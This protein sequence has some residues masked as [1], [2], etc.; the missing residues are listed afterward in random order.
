VVA[1]TE[2]V[3]ARLEAEGKPPLAVIEGPLM[4]GMNV[5]GDLCSAPARCSCPRWSSR[6][7]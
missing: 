3:R 2:E 7:A 4:A 5:V 6:P 1:D